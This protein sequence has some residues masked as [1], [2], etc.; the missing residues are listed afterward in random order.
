MDIGL[1]S[2]RAVM[3]LGL[4]SVALSACQQDGGMSPTGPSAGGGM[5]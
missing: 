5:R 4:L 1:K 2:A 3:A